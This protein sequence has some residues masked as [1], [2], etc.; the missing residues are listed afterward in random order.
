MTETNSPLASKRKREAETI[1]TDEETLYEEH[2][3]LCKEEGFPQPLHYEEFKKSKWSI[4]Y[5]IRR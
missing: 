1:E 4:R 3:R 5:D 2:N